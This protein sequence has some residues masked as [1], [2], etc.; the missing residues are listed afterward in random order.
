VP[1]EKQ[2]AEADKAAAM[3]DWAR[4]DAMTDQ[5]IEAAATSDPDNPPL[6][7]EQLAEARLIVHRRRKKPAAAE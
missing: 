2:R 1:T 7:D 3:V 4:L 5:E 6:T